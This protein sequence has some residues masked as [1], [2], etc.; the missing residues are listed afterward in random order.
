M[1]LE[2]IELIRDM[3]N[4]LEIPVQT[5]GTIRIDSF[6]R[7]ILSCPKMHHMIRSSNDHTWIK[8]MRSNIVRCVL[9]PTEFNTMHGVRGVRARSA[10]ILIISL[11]HCITH[12]HR[13]TPDNYEYRLY[14]S[15]ISSNITKYLTRASRS[16]TTLHSKTNIKN[17][18]YFEICKLTILCA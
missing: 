15:L 2:D 12:S 6:R 4:L 18:R 13:Y 9:T 10:R 14:H 8:K 5:H 11:K 17:N 7:M 1:S 3:W 16:N